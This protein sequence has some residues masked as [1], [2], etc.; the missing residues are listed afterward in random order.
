MYKITSTIHIEDWYV[1]D[2]DIGYFETIEEAMELF[3]KLREEGFE[4]NYSLLDDYIAGCYHK[5]DDPDF[6]DFNKGF[7]IFIYNNDDVVVYQGFEYD[8][9]SHSTEQR[10]EI[11]FDLELVTQE[12]IRVL[13]DLGYNRQSVG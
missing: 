5:D 13:L 4:S 1:S 2:M 12:E 7:I 8:H 6:D 9:R 11:I 10:S 3:R